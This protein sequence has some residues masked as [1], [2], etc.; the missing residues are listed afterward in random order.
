MRDRVLTRFLRYHG[1][2]VVGVD[3]ADE[4][5]AKARE[6]DPYGEYH[7]IVPGDS[8]TS[9]N[10]SNSFCRRCRSITCR[11]RTRRCVHSLR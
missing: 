6:K 11:P 10:N 7:V 1:F 9:R 5:I 3:I 2:S 4:M 8:G